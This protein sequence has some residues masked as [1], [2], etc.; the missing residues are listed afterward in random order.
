MVNEKEI[1][2]QKLIVNNAIKH[3]ICQETGEIIE[4]T[5]I[6]KPIGRQG[7]MITYLESIINLIEVLG[8]RKMHIVKYILTEMDKNNNTLLTTTRELSEKT[9]T[10]TRTVVET[11]K[12][13]ENAQIIQRRLG[14]IMINPN[15]LHR[16]REAKER[17]LVTRFFEFDN[18]K[19]PDPLSSN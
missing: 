8:N 9:K 2:E 3:W 15:L 12:I 11:L 6:M 18:N 4:A 14:A 5:E 10:S 16:G 13:L 1:K 17:A 7:F 19:K